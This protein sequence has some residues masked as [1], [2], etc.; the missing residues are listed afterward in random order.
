MV[1]VATSADPS[2]VTG[3]SCE[4]PGTE[5]GR[6]RTDVCNHTHVHMNHRGVCIKL[7]KLLVSVCGMVH[8]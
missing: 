6:D 4:E 5:V 2:T 8:A 3:G 1:A 7:C